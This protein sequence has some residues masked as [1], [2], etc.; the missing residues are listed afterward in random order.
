M[1]VIRVADV[2]ICV[3]GTEGR[4]MCVRRMRVVFR[5]SEDGFVRNDIAWC[6]FSVVDDCGL[7]IR[8]YHAAFGGSRRSK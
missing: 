4:G 2:N 8:W 7:I 3:T 6:S 1:R 5:I